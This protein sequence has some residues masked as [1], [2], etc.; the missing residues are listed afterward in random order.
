MT[1]INNKLTVTEI[2]EY[3]NDAREISKGLTGHVANTT[4]PKFHETMKKIGQDPMLTAQGKF[5]KKEKFRKQQ[6]VKLLGEISEAKETY[7]LL[8]S[9]AQASAEAI[10]LSD[11]EKPDEKAIKLFEL[12]KNRLQSAVMFAPNA[13]AKTKTLSEFA[14]LGEKGQYFAREIQGEFIGL[15]QQAMAGVTD[16]Q[17]LANLTRSLGKINTGLQ[18]AAFTED[19]HKA[20]ELLNSVTTY[21]SGDFVN[22][23]VLGDSLMTISKVTHDYANNLEG[24][25]V[26]HADTIEEVERLKHYENPIQ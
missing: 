11:V 16:P 10:L 5:D 22:T 19:Q 17:A 1:K 7:N 9:D 12:E 24:Y 8:L 26:D 14:K 18:A 15:S 25:Q 6:E 13:D 3:L 4:L 20:S 23:I 2:R 21:Q